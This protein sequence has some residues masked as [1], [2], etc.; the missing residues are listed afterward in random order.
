MKTLQQLLDGKKYKEV[1]SIAPHRPVFDAL[2]ILAEYK[3]G[4]LIVLDGQNLVGIFSERDYAREVIL[5][6]RSSKTTSINEVMTSK[7]LTANP[8][9]SVEHALS[10]MTEH[11]IRHLPVVVDEKV[12]G[13]LSIGDLVKET[14]AYQQELIKQLQSYIKS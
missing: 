3:I 4:A 13:V 1:I 2:V 12:V 9:D 8:N 7:V 6:G 10:L 14:I 11:R 5:K